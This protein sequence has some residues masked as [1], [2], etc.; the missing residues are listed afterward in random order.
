M[1]DEYS[2]ELVAFVIFGS[3]CGY[4]SIFFLYHLEKRIGEKF[5]LF[6]IYKMSKLISPETINKRCE[7]L[8]RRYKEIEPYLETLNCPSKLS[9]LTEQ[10]KNF[11]NNKVLPTMVEYQLM[12]HDLQKREWEKNKL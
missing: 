4:V 8:T 5:V 6:P 12:C 3:F 1:C 7:E 10:E 9:A 2:R 11:L